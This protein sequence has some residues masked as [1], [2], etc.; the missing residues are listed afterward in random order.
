MSKN[1]LFQTDH[2]DFFKETFEKKA[3]TDYIM[4]QDGTLMPYL[5]SN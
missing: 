1:I 2:L 4:Q 5:K 3:V